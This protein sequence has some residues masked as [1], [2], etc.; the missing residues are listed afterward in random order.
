MR[1]FLFLILT[2]NFLIGQPDVRKKGNNTVK[3]EIIL[4]DDPTGDFWGLI[5]DEENGDPIPSVKVEIIGKNIGTMTDLD[6]KFQFVKVEPGI[7]TI[8]ISSIGYQSKEIENIK[9]KK[10]EIRISN[11]VMSVQATTQ[12][13]VVIQSTIERELEAAAVI[14]Q[15][16][17]LRLTDIFS[18][19]LILKSSPNLMLGSA[20]ARMPGVS[21][22]EDKS[23][24][25]RGLSERYALY[26]LNGIP[27]PVSNI[28][29]KTFDFDAFPTISVLTLD[30]QKSNLSRDIVG[31][32]AAKID[33]A[34][35]GIPEKNQINAGLQFFFNSNSSFKKL[36]RYDIPVENN[37]TPNGF[38]HL[39]S[40]S[41]YQGLS[42]GDPIMVDV[43]K[44]ESTTNDPIEYNGLLGRRLYAGLQRRI[45]KENTIIGFSFLIDA[46]ENN[47]LENRS[48]SLVGTY[49]PIIDV[50][51]IINQSKIYTQKK[52]INGLLSAGVRWKSNEF[53]IRFY[54]TMNVNNSY[55]ENFGK[56]INN[57]FERTYLDFAYFPRKY[58]FNSISIGQLSASHLFGKL[59]KVRLEWKL[60]WNY[61][62]SRIPRNRQVM[63]FYDPTYQ[64]YLNE[65]P[66]LFPHTSTSYYTYQLTSTQKEN[67]R[68]V[69]LEFSLP[70]KKNK[71]Y[72]G[73]W[74]SFADHHFRARE[75]GYFTENTF[76]IDSAA[77]SLANYNNLYNPNNIG[78]NGYLLQE[79]TPIYDNFNANFNNIAVYA[80]TEWD[81][82]K[83]LFLVA[84][85]RAEFY[86]QK[87][88][89][90]D[91]RVNGQTLI[92][93]STTEVLPSVLLRYRPF[94]KLQ[95]KLKYSKTINRPDFRDISQMQ[96][97]DNING[98]LWQ[99]N[100]NLKYTIISALDLRI[101]Y[102][103]SGKEIAS[104]SLFYKNIKNPIEQFVS[105]KTSGIVQSI[106]IRNGNTAHL[107]GA[108]LEIRKNF[109]FFGKGFENFLIQANFAFIR[110]MQ[111]DS[112]EQKLDNRYGLQGQSDYI[113]N[114]G[115]LYDFPK[116]NLQ[117]GAFY[118]RIGKLIAIEGAARD[119]Y[120]DIYQLSRDN[121]DV[122]VMKEFKRFQLKFVVQDVFN[123]PYRRAQLHDPKRF[124][125]S[126]D[127][128][129]YNS[130]RGIKSIL[131][132]S[133]KF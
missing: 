29:R 34:T 7:Y 56:A 79:Y 129:I 96:Y 120:P 40:Q 103:F 80:Q 101:E 35:V 60:Y 51:V 92:D 84:G 72:Y 125:P 25:I 108:E 44:K 19:Q 107:G 12:E 2:V 74:T 61:A 22:I 11:I 76:G 89:L 63:M 16:N 110:S 14:Q 117:F 91:N 100:S 81:L 67:N 43:S 48:S 46:M 39:P 124:D 32:A 86:S 118:N 64:T 38:N 66:T 59:E 49:E 15:I 112:L 119:V 115:F 52:F 121:V 41:V 87:M 36:K 30:L 116:I 57:A 113:H 53:L 114:I 70:L 98:F 94:D 128:L 20:L 33:L 104:L 105:S 42:F 5:I 77:L 102:L 54:Q 65:I 21:T 26:T 62:D 58:F 28:E 131:S 17:S 50:P 24:N 68:G 45:L 78:T 37:Y 13:E 55:N 133:Y 4:T 130:R 83:K 126:K 10:G 132:V 6:G 99:G 127:Q 111:Y 1:I 109:G 93:T 73:F 75:L 97:W 85:F 106:S 82:T 88:I 47:D 18:T 69:S 71:M 27:M 9:V 123:Q 23:I 95:F 31:G 8:K 90:V 122:Q 3:E